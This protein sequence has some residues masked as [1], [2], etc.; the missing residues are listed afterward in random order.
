MGIGSELQGQ[1]RQKGSRK[2]KNIIYY[3][4]IYTYVYF[5]SWD[6][7]K[8][9]VVWILCVCNI[10]NLHELHKSDV[11]LFKDNVSCGCKR[12]GANSFEEFPNGV[13]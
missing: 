1:N 11:L 4:N 8:K 6:V 10:L 12:K 3:E 7:I 13:F 5:M 2:Y 9:N